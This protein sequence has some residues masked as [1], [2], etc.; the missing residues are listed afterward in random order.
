M[1]CAV[2]IN[3][4]TPYG[5]PGGAL[6]SVVVSGTATIGCEVV[7]VTISCGGPTP[8]PPQ[9]V[10]YPGGG[11]NWPWTATFDLTG[12]AGTGCT[13]GQSELVVEALCQ[14]PPRC[15]ND[16]KVISPI[17]CL[18][19]CPT[20]TLT[21]SLGDCDSQGHRSVSFTVSVTPASDP[22]CPS[23]DSTVL[24]TL[25]FGDA[26]GNSTAFSAQPN[27]P[28]I[29]SHSYAPGTYHPSVS[30]VSPSGCAATKTIVNVP[31]CGNGGGGCSPPWNPR[32]WTSFC[33]ALLAAA[34]ADIL[35]AG[36]LITLA[37][38][39]NWLNYWHTLRA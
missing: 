35:A 29:A 24:G 11:P 31:S 2:T 15:S 37:G 6:S 33:G 22:D 18:S 3:T 20:I 19:C 30:L 13:C 5:S 23:S 32:C 28:F 36:V 9:T 16:R 34:L 14:K 27:I 39:A 8:I 21:S 10:F 4:V 17:P 25:D 12:L 7:Q 1:D 38:C 26:A